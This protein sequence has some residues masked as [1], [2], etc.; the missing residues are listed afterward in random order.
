MLDHLC[1][2]SRSRNGASVLSLHEAI[3]G[4]LSLFLHMILLISGNTFGNTFSKSPIFSGENMTWNLR[5]QP[6]SCA[7]ERY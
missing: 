4:F 3:S 5:K 7:F 2:V 6:V 1:H